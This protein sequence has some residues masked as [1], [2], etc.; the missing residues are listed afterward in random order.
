[1]YLEKGRT[2]KAKREIQSD[3]KKS[4]TP[5]KLHIV[6]SNFFSDSNMTINYS[7]VT[8]TEHI[9]VPHVYSG[10]REY[11]WIGRKDIVEFAISEAI[12]HLDN[13]LNDEKVAKHPVI[14]K[15]V[16]DV[17]VILENPKLE[18]YPF[19]GNSDGLA[20]QN[21]E[22][23]SISTTLIAGALNSNEK[24][25]RLEKTLIHE[26]FH[27]IGGCTEDE[28]KDLICEDNVEKNIAFEKIVSKKRIQQME[29]DD[30]A[31]FIMQC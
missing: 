17:K 11:S 28:S 25:Y 8:S 2:Q 5:Q 16:Q 20:E 23:I 7:R 1:M 22:Q 31:Q 19:L 3:K 6:R 9:F 4:P 10:K 24:L 21:K 26:A 15:A 13:A 30:F 12:K 29:A 18:I 27:I 14:K